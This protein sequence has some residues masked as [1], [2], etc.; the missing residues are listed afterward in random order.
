VF[1]KIIIGLVC[2]LALGIGWFFFNFTVLLPRDIP[3][4]E[5]TLPTSPEQI[6]RGRYL[7][8]HVAVC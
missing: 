7:A 4:P 3:I 2:I 1:K 5:I 6:E 8:T